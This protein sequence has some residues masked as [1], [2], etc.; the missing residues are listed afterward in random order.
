VGNYFW[1][2]ASVRELAQGQADQGPFA[3]AQSF[4]LAQQPPTLSAQSMQ[5]SDGETTVNLRWQAQAGQRFRLQLARDIGFEKPTLDTTLD[6]P[7]WTAADLAAG[8]YFV[9]IQVLDPSGLQSDFSPPRSIRVGTGFSTSSGL[10][11]SDSS[12]EA[13]RRP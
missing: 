13:V 6:E 11:V 4:V 8:T 5:A 1:R 3:A 2:A 12:G 7:Q 9:R 10:P